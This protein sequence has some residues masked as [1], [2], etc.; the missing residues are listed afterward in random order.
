MAI[1]FVFPI[2]LA[3]LSTWQQTTVMGPAV[4]PKQRLPTVRAVAG[5]CTTGPSQWVGGAPMSKAQR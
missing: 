1:L 3:Q 5:G 4:I 2:I